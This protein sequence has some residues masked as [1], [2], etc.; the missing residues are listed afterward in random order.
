MSAATAAMHFLPDHAERVVGIGFHR[1]INRSVEARPAGP[2]IELGVGGK[3]RQIATGT[4]VSIK[5]SIESVS[6]RTLRIRLFRL[7]VYE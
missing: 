1:A 5:L 4:I 3:Q 2:R 7:S 6:A